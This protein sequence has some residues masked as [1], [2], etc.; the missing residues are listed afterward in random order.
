MILCVWSCAESLCARLLPRSQTVKR[1]AERRF[2]PIN[3]EYGEDL[4]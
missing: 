2:A 3:V 4:V 1:G